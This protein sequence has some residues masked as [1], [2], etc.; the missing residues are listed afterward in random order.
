M[1]GKVNSKGGTT[2]TI[3]NWIPAALAVAMI[4]VESTITMSA[5]NT[6]RWLLPVWVYFFG[7]ISAALCDIIHHIIRKM[8]HFT[9]CGVVTLCFFHGWRTSLRA[10][11]GEF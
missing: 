3:L 2:S 4:V 8:G 7:P 11:A 6:S 1:T 5:N 9:G 10:A